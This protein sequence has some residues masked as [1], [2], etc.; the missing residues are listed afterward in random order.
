MGKFLK[1]LRTQWKAASTVEKVGIFMDLICS[2][3]SGIIAF[4]AGKKLSEGCG[5]VPSLCIQVTTMGA[6]MAL[7]DIASEKLKEEYA[8]TIGGVIDR[9]KGKKEEAGNE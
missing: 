6:G 2:A 5:V 3:G 9:I 7:G 4:N 1:E 8:P